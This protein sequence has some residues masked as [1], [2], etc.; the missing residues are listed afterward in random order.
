MAN[1][2]KINMDQGW[3]RKV[4]TINRISKVVKGGRRMRFS[5]LVVTG[6]GAGLVGYGHEKAGEVSAAIAKAEKKAMKSLI[7]ISLEGPSIPFSF[8]SKFG[9]SRILLKPARKGRGLVAAKSVRAVMEAVGV[10]DVV[11]KLFG[12]HNPLNVVKAT[13]LGLSHLSEDRE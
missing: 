3:I 9:A 5:A 13:L 6:N 2:Q 11:T 12:S 10:S 7:K 4:V 1:H 8:T